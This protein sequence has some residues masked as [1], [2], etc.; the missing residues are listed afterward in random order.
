MDPNDSWNTFINLLHYH[1]NKNIPTITTKGEFNPPWFDAE[2]HSKCREKERLHKKYVSTKAIADGIKYSNCRKE[3]KTLMRTKM[4]DNLYNSSE[5]NNLISKKFC[6]YVKSS[7]NTHRIPEV[8]SLDTTTSSDAKTK[9]NLFNQYFFQQFS[10]ASNYEIDINVDNDSDFDINYS[11]ERIEKLLKN[12]NTN[13]A[14]GPDRIPGIVLKRYSNVLAEALSIIF[15]VI[16]NTGI[17]P[18]E[19]KLA[20]V[21]PIF[22]KGTRKI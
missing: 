3:F 12:V 5:D 14:G 17:V 1:L 13:K 19:W 16:Y 22:K 8:M 15:K 6:G 18:S 4:R 10:E 2:C 11:P 21:V 7:S 20:N 9:A